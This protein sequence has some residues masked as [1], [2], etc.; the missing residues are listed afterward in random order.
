MGNIGTSY[1][2]WITDGGASES[3]GLRGRIL[4]QTGR[5]KNMARAICS[6]DGKWL[7]YSSNFSDDSELYISPFP[8]PGPR[9]KISANGAEYGIWAPD[10]SAVYYIQEGLE[11]DMW[12]VI[13]NLEPEFSFEKP[14]SLFRGHYYNSRR[15]YRSG[16]FDIHPDG[17]HFLMLNNTE[18]EL[19][20][21]IKVIVNW[22][23]ELL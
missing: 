5:S 14:K 17:D 11:S 2:H 21:G 19:P 15:S 6:P 12:E 8:G 23:Q 20:P 10:M 22:E 13:L 7:L 16:R 1:L 9:Y 18:I 4:G 3:K